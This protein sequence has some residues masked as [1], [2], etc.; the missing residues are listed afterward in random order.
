MRVGDTV[1][2]LAAKEHL[3]QNILIVR[4]IKTDARG[5]WIQFEETPD[6]TWHAGNMYR[7]A[8]AGR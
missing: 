6:D 8:N 3:S 1:V 7:A 2:L 4:S 5:V